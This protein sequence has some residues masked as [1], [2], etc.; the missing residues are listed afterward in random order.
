MKRFDGL[1]EKAREAVLTVVGNSD[2][3]L[4]V[5]QITKAV[6]A[7]DFASLDKKQ[8]RQ[9]IQNITDRLM[10]HGELTIVKGTKSTG[11]P[12]NQY[13]LSNVTT[14]ISATEHSV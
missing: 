1:Q 7:E 6:N 4:S 2:T 14:V 8:L 10:R 5:S 13:Q 12:V 11:R 3:P 9:F